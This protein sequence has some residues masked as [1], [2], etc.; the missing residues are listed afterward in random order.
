M[1]SRAPQVHRMPTQAEL[2]ARQRAENRR[3]IVGGAVAAL[4]TMAALIGIL[5][6][7]P[8]PARAGTPIPTIDPSRHCSAPHRVCPGAPLHFV[9]IR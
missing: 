7:G 6:V 1:T 8:V 2:A 9:K 4:A 5:L 3:T